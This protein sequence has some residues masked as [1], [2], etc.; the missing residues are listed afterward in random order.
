MS[1]F[2][3][4]RGSEMPPMQVKE[5]KETVAE[6]ETYPFLVN[7]DRGIRD[8]V[9]K[10]LGYRMKL[11]P[12]DGSTPIAAY[13]PIRINGMVKAWKKR[14]YL[15]PK[16]HAFSIIGNADYSADLIGADKLKPGKKIYI[17]EGEEDLAATLQALGDNIKSNPKW[18]GKIWPNVVSIVGGAPYAAENI[19]H[20]MHIIDRYEE[21]VT[22]FDSDKCTRQEYNKGYRRGYEATCETHLAIGFNKCKYL[23]MD[24]KDPSEYLQT[25]K[26]AD[27]EKLL[28]WGA[29]DFTP[30]TIENGDDYSVEDLRAPNTPGVPIRCLPKTSGIIRGLREYEATLVLAPSKCFGIGTPIRMADG[31]IKT[32]E[33]IVVG[34]TVMGHDSKPRTVKECHNG[35]SNM[36]LIEQSKGM[37]YIANE[38]HD[39]V[40]YACSDV[41]GINKGKERIAP[42]KDLCD[43]RNALNVWKQRRVGYDLPEAKLDIDPY[44]LGVWLADGAKSC[45]AITVNNRDF[46]IIQ[47]IE[48]NYDYSIKV[49]KDQFKTYYLKRA[50]HL[51]RRA[52]L[53]D[54]KHVPE[55]YI[56]ASLS[57]RASLLAGFLDAEGYNS[58][59]M[60][61][62]VQKCE[63]VTK[64]ILEVC[65]SLGLN[66]TV[67]TKTVE[68]YGDYFR[69]FVRGDFSMIPMGRKK[70]SQKKD[71]SLSKM[72]FTPLGLGE[73][74][75]FSVEEE[76]K[77][78]LLADGTIVHN[79]G[80]S[81]LTKQIGYDVMCRLIEEEDDRK[82]GHIFL[83]ENGKKTRQS[84]IALDTGVSLARLR[85]DPT[86]LSE[87]EFQK[88]YDKLYASGKNIFLSTR[89]GK[90]SPEQVVTQLRYMYAKGCR[91]IIFDHLSM[92]VS[93]SDNGN[94]RKEIDNL[95]T[96]IAA[97]CEGNPVHVIVVAHVKRSDYRPKTDDD[98]DVI[99]PYWHPVGPEDARGSAAFSQLFWNC[100]CIE[101][102][103]C[104]EA[105]NINRVRTKVAFCRE[106]GSR[107][108]GDTMKYNPD[109]GR[110]EIIGGGE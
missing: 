44:T 4:P 73:Y 2:Y 52:G 23:P 109:N 62:F 103:I 81:T 98:G 14:D 49:E 27:F 108:I 24:L 61:E 71:M 12:K 34:D 17:T 8:E 29:I 1:G 87:R 45:P 90:L 110:L 22:C 10:Y 54:N 104:D 42:V 39:L 47:H 31:S 66:Y 85:E 82:V 53:I 58:G 7:K 43:K 11:D 97:F 20:N 78:F 84:Y 64:G 56:Q 83:E 6:I 89:E 26:Q 57:Q 40:L 25:G 79:S 59:N 41:K 51:F 46:N 96:E 76:D 95:L 36:Y 68:G 5:V 63:K 88:S 3:K 67:T 92:V 107:G 55:K 50:M 105:G 72:K 28:V 30:V 65:T 19:T 99:Y 91:V 21:V 60:I 48:S 33:S 94:E 93:G 75:G 13:Y 15:K 77:K 70:P 38:E 16:K 106:W 35:L 101:P 100:I 32:I 69:V 9:Y 80:K 74:F 37:D 86:V 18:K 102:E